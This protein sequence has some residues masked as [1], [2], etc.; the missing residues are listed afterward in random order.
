MLFEM[1]TAAMTRG[2]SS[3]APKYRLH[4]ATGQARVTIRGITFYLGKHGSEQSNQKYKQLLADEWNLGSSS[5]TPP[6]KS[7]AVPVTVTELAID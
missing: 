6:L 2:R 3:S 7:A 5:Q 1:E 4:K